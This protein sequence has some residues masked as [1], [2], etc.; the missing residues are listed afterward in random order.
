MA[1]TLKKKFDV[2]PEL[3]EGGGGN[4]KVWADGTLLWDKKSMG[5]EFPTESLIVE[6]IEQMRAA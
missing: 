2:A 3:I 1:V 6:K 5:N 4:F